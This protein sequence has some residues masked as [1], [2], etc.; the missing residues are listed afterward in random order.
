MNIPAI[1]LINYLRPIAK[2]HNL[3]LNRWKD[4]KIALQIAATLN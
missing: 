1:Y 2:K 4:I 3:R